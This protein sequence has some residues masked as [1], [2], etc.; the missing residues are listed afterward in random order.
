MCLQYGAAHMISPS[1]VREAFLMSA[2]VCVQ[3]TETFIAYLDA[4]NVN[5][6]VQIAA[7]LIGLVPQQAACLPLIVKDN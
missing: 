2:S 7:P 1:T 5:I 6:K 4:I 3:D